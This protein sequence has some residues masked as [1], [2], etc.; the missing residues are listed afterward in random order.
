MALHSGVAYTDITTPHVH[1]KNR[2]HCLCCAAAKSMLNCYS[3]PH[4]CFEP[5]ALLVG[6]TSPSGIICITALSRDTTLEQS[7]WS[8]KLWLSCHA[9]ASGMDADEGHAMR[10]AHPSRHR[11]VNKKKRRKR[12]EFQGRKAWPVPRIRT[13]RSSQI[14]LALALL[15]TYQT[16]VAE[17]SKAMQ[18]VRRHLGIV[19][20]RWTCEKEE[21]FQLKPSS[22]P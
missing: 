18:I 7:G 6:N 12:H 19:A 16:H 10:V 15:C 9:S 2:N 21:T 20:W 11:N 17:K 14:P 3:S 5:S 4:S 13:L 1:S 22:Q 8:S